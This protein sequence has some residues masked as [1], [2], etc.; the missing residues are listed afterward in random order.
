MA[1]TLVFL[2]GTLCDE[3]VWQPCEQLL[4]RQL[5]CHH[6]AYGF[7][8]SIAAMAAAVLEAVPGP[9]VPAGSSMGGIVALEMAR[10][11]PARIAGMALFGVNPGPDTPERHAG[12][13]EQLRFAREHGVA[14][15]ARDLLAPAWFASAG[16]RYAALAEVAVGMAV[17]LG[18]GRLE[19]QF[20]ALAGRA[21]S[22]PLLPLLAAP[23]LV[24]HGQADRVCPP[25]LHRQMA[26][27]LPQASL[28]EIAGAG[29]LAP[30]EQGTTCAA[31]LRDWLCQ[32][33][34]IGA[35]SPLHC[36]H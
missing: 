24:A 23:V 31:L 19:A 4:G 34:L 27:L 8:N 22:W 5:P 14:A 2:P 20:E 6:A 36:V 10:Q 3:R 17:T 30:L 18:T 26:A 21:D 1:P 11:A 29:H 16:E 35:A 25:A 12:R 33:G 7:A 32:E 13:A 28:L 15:L 9:L